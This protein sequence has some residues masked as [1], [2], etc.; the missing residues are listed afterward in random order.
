LYSPTSGDDIRLGAFDDIRLAQIPHLVDNL[1]GSQGRQAREFFRE[2]TR[3][4]AA[5]P[6]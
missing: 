5:D 3:A 6:P 1:G 4:R 2:D